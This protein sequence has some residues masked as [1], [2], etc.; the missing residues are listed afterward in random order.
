MTDKSKVI[1]G[2]PKV[3]GAVFR[4]P[5]GTAIPTD[6]RTALPAAYKELGYVSSDGWARQIQKAYETITAWGGDEAA[7][8]RKEHSVTFSATLIEDLNEDVQV[9]KWG[10]AAVETTPA[11]ATHGNLITVTYEG[12]D[13]EPGVWVFDMNDQGKLHRTVF[14]YAQDTTESF[15]QTFSDSD[16]IGLPFEM[17]A[18]KDA[19]L[20][21]HFVDCMDDGKITA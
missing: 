1:A 15:E 21:V 17:T 9:A 11:S 12:E 18:Y 7:K 19:T 8:S 5:L 10:T 3:G 6:A 20:G 14:P 2:K 4:A 16:A 13:T